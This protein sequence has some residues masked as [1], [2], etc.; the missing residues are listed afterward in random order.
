MGSTDI[1][2]NFNPG[3]L[4]DA[5]EKGYLVIFDNAENMSIEL[6]EQMDH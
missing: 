4:M 3:V 6:L 1:K 2:G 5:V